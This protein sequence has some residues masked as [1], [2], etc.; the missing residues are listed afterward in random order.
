MTWPPTPR[1]IG[2]VTS[3]YTGMHIPHTPPHHICVCTSSM[4]T[5]SPIQWQRQCTPTSP[6][7]PLCATSMQCWCNNDDNAMTMTCC[8]T[9][10]CTHHTLFPVPHSESGWPVTQWWC[11]N[12]AHTLPK[13]LPLPPLLPLSTIMVPSC[14]HVCYHHD[15]LATRRPWQVLTTARKVLL[16]TITLKIGYVSVPNPF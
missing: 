10:H 4:C 14:S 13:S 2:N 5:P 7:F 12:L 11:D 1:R 16:G 8:C 3:F 15:E 6:T 9:H